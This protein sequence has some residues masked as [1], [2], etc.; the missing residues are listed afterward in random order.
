M[1]TLALLDYIETP[2]FAFTFPQEGPPRIVYWNARAEKAMGLPRQDVV[3]QVPSDAMGTLAEPLLSPDWLMAPGE[4]TIGGLGQVHLHPVPEE[5]TVVCTVLDDT[6]KE[7]D[8]ERETFI[9]MAVHDARAPLRNINFLCEELLVNFEDPGD[10]RNHLVRKIRAIAD[11][12]LA[13]SDDI[14]TAVHAAAL[15]SAPDSM[16]D[17]QPL[18][19]MVFATLDPMG[20][21]R[22]TSAPAVLELERP[23]LQVVLRNLIDNAIRHGAQDTS[24]SIRVQVKTQERGFV[25]ITVSDD[26]SGI[27]D[28]ALN[29]LATGEV[30]RG[31]GFGLYGVQRLVESRGG[32]ISAR[33]LPDHTGSTISIT[34]PGRILTEEERSEILRRRVVS[35]PRSMVMHS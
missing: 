7:A 17:L 18:C 16:V 6:H 12:T 9:G 20:K 5:R 26:G 29:F 28:E 15:K 14:L 31:S 30:R 19:D 10:G 21:H 2:A 35:R 22:L 23:V 11:Q 33:R 25:V 1:E 8:A 34:L 4:V 24:L 13:L 3:G 32:H 27:P